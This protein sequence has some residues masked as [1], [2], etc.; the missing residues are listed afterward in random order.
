MVNE[1]LRKRLPDDVLILDNAS[2]DNSIIGVTL[3]GRL[4]YSYGRM[5]EEYREENNCD[6]VDAIE[7]VEFNTLR[8]L[9]YM[10]DKAP[11]VMFEY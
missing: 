8:A 9:P 6:E 5:V 3:D 10:G 2:Y 1:K 4:I 11:I 7:W